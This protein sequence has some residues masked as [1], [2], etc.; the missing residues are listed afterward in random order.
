MRWRRAGEG[1]V[2]R[3]KGRKR[4]VEE[5]DVEEEEVEED[6]VEDRR[7]IALVEATGMMFHMVLFL[8]FMAPG[9]P[10]KHWANSLI[11]VILALLGN[12]RAISRPRKAIGSEKAILHIKHG[13]SL[14]F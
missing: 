3:G 11:Y 2:G 14:G 4:S 1:E 9:R 7:T 13:L 8:A 6:E 12:I 10:H 5:E